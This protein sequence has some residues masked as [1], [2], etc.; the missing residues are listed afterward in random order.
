LSKI[1]LHADEAIREHLYTNSLQ[2]LDSNYQK[3][4]RFLEVNFEW[5]SDGDIVLLHDW[6]ASIS[7]FFGAE[8]KQYSLN[9]FKNFKMID[10]LRQMDLANLSNWLASSYFLY[11]Y[12]C[13]I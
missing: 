12:R 7:N 1:I 13:K 3:G 4:Y 10:N 8:K 2:A 6:Q 9:E 11:R 5:T